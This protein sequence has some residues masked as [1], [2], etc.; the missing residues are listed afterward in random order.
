MTA[1]TLARGP[2]A[3]PGELA[4]LFCRGLPEQARR[5][6]IAA[7]M[8]V[9]REVEDD[10]GRPTEA[11]STFLRYEIEIGYQGPPEL[12]DRE[13]LVLLAEKLDYFTE[14]EAAGKLRFPHSAGKFRKAAV[15]ND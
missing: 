1:G 12:Q 2:T 7:E 14:D 5:F 8:L 11:T 10:F 3:A 9:E 6:R 15:H 13:R 4:D